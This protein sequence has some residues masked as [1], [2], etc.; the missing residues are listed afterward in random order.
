[1]NEEP[2]LQL[3]KIETEMVVMCKPDRSEV[4]Y[5][6]RDNIEE[7]L[8][9]LDSNH[10]EIISL[11]VTKLSQ[12]PH[13]WFNSIPFGETHDRSCSIIWSTVLTEKEREQIKLERDKQQIK[14]DL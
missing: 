2:V 4:E 5:I 14:L 6:V 1:M 10:C 12:I 7:H 9:T 13:T 3:V 11:P 8:S